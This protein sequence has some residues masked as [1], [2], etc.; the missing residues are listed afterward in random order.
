MARVLR[1]LHD[2]QEPVLSEL[3]HRLRGVGNE[4]GLR[5]Q[6]AFVPRQGFLVVAHRDTGEE[7]HLQDPTLPARELDVR[8]QSDGY[9]VELVGRLVR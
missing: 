4:A 5:T 6:E 1:P 8:K 9:R 3:P 2:E 7:V